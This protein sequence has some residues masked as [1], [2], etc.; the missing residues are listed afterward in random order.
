MGHNQN[1][2]EP[3]KRAPEPQDKSEIKTHGG[4]RTSV[5]DRVLD[6]H[7]VAGVVT[8]TGQRQ[9]PVTPDTGGVEPVS[10]GPGLALG[11]PGHSR[12][13]DV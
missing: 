2:S 6:G 1:G 3:V 13:D 5:I 11:S 9:D 4:R 8:V 7:G 10:Q 12:R